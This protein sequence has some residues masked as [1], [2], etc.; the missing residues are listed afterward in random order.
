MRHHGFR[1]DESY[2]PAL[3][4]GGVSAGA[5]G[6]TGAAGAGCRGR[7]V[8]G[9]GAGAGCD[10]TAAGAFSKSAGMRLTFETVV[11]G[12][13]TGG[14]TVLPTVILSASGLPVFNIGAVA[15][16]GTT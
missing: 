5:V 8:R 14:A 10:A 2:S 13:P 16:A 11:A 4:V 7:W 1:V 3:V 12:G 6:G 15:V 9:A